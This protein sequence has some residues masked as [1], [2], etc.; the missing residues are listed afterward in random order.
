[1]TSFI[2][3]RHGE[4]EWN[5]ASRIQGH[6]DSALTA[7]GLAQ[8]DAIAARLAREPFDV[9]VSSDLGR[10]L[11]TSRRIAAACGREVVPDPR[12]RERN[13]GT[14]EGLTYAELHER[15]PHAFGRHL[16]DQDPDFALPEAETRRGFYARIAAAFEALA[17]ECAGSRIA[18]V[19][20]GGVLA[21][22]YRHIHG[23]PAERPASVDIPNA[24][25]NRVVAEEGRWSVEAWADIA[26]FG[27]DVGESAA[28]RG[29]ALRRMS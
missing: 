22:L 1:L 23:I 29:S 3:V 7:V 26:H 21:A 2:V 4:T 20:H 17:R 27:E 18:V 25:Y 5:L 24:A 14:A 13:F 19:C 12:F 8:A 28:A 6:G 15:Y 9:L 16:Q 11:E 10:A